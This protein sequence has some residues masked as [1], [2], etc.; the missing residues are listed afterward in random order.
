MEAEPF[1]MSLYY[2]GFGRS[3]H[4]VALEGGRREDFQSELKFK[5]FKVGPWPHSLCELSSRN[6]IAS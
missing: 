3:R 1:L 2:R 5:D 4:V 6:L